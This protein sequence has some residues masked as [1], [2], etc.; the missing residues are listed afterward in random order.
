M[1]DS[2]TNP[3]TLRG[4]VVSAKAKDTITVA[5]ER[6]VKHPKYHKFIKRTKR[7]QAHDSGNTAQEGDEVTIT[8]TRPVSKTK[9]FTLTR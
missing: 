7:Y 1:S 5:V 3:R 6:F 9:R 8:E 2:S 4:T